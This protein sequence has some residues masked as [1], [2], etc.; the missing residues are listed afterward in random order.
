MTDSVTTVREQ[1]W[2]AFALVV[3]LLGL[4]LVLNQVFLWD[5]LG[6]G[7]LRNEFLYYLLACFGSLVF[8]FFRARKVAPK[9][10][11]DAVDEL[12]AREHRCRRRDSP[13]PGTT[14]S[15]SPSP[16]RRTSTSP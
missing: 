3:T 13:S 8:V 7:M 2:R 1:A 10:G 11:P 12:E 4:F 16:P 14:P 15:S 9:D 6:G 5:L